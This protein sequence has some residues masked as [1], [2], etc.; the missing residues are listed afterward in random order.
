[1]QRRE[2]LI[3][4]GKAVLAPSVVALGVGR[5]GGGAPAAERGAGEAAPGGAGPLT[6]FLSGDVMTGRGIDQ[7][8]PHSVDPRLYEPW[9]LD[10]RTYVRLAEERNG[11]IPRD[12]PYDYVWG[13]ALDELARIR[14]DLR[15][16]NL[17]TA[18]T[19]S[20]DHWPHKA[21]HYRMHPANVPVLT[22]A[23]IDACVLGNNHVM[24]WGRD[25]LEETLEALR[26]AGL[27][28]PGAGVDDQAAVAPAELETG[29][30]RLLVFSY[31]SP[32]AGV[33]P[34]WRA[35]GDEPGVSLLPELGAPGAR[36]IIEDVRAHRR[37]GDRVVVSIHWGG[38]WGYAVPPEQREL[39]HQLVDAGAADVVHGHSSHHPK[40]IEVYRGGPILYGA[41]DFLN[42]YEGIPGHE[43][44]R[45]DLTL[46]YFPGLDA[47]GSLTSLE[48]VPMRI[49][50]FRLERA[51][52]E[53]AAW[54][55]AT[56]DR[57]SR[58]FGARVERI[59]EGRLALRWEAGS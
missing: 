57:E 22:A 50:R 6:L 21:I 58:G 59:A 51:S 55:A 2:F 18:V 25:G 32:T 29:S 26:V 38:N 11:P 12:V 24:D 10:A 31:G 14:P 35:S 56:V 54:L 41:G 28:A 39:A 13:D 42:D 33:P 30:G 49:R 52:E 23:G 3:R 36:V 34:K 17:E 48:M 27:H 16:I 1:M 47:S 5:C 37:E 53:E 9:V 19:T 43:Q 8:L 20:D 44:F 4:S 40:G 45:G 15:I 7:I 46:M